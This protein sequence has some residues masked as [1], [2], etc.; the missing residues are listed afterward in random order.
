MRFESV[1]AHAF[2]PFANKRLEFSPG[3][4]VIYGP[5]ESG[6][7]TW[8][9]VLYAGL[10]GLRRARGQ[11]R[12]D[13]RD[14]ADRHKPWD[15]QSWEVSAR[16][17]LDDGRHIE[18]RHDLNG[19]ADCAATDLTLGRDVTGEIINEGSPDGARWLGLDRRSFLA[20]AC[21][22]QAD[23][24]GIRKGPELL[25]EHLQRAA[26][27]TRTD[28]TATEAITRLQKFHDTQVGSDRARS[29]KPFRI[30]QER[31][32]DAETRLGRAKNEHQGFLDL[33]AQAEGL[34]C[35]AETRREALR[36]L[37]ALAA[38]RDAEA[39][40]RRAS[41]ARELAQR[42]QGG[43][44][45]PLAEDDALARQIAAAI[46]SWE[47]RSRVAELK[48]LSAVELQQRIDALPPMPDGD[49]E[50]HQDIA[51]A[52]KAYED[53]VRVFELHESQQLPTS[54]PPERR[55]T[56]E[57]ELRD[58]A[59]DLEAAEPSIDPVLQE[60]FQQARD[61][62][63]RLK[64]WSWTALLAAAGLAGAGT[65]VWLVVS[66]TV[67]TGLLV[68]VAAGALVA[69]GLA[70]AGSA[71]ARAL[72]ELR[73]A[74]SAV[75]GIRHTIAE[76]VRLREAA[77]DRAR[78]LRLSA[79]PAVLRAL[80]DEVSAAAQQRREFERWAE[81]STPLAE[82][83][84]TT[85]ADLARA[86]R[87]RG[88][89]VGDDVTRALE[90][91]RSECAGRA[92]TAVEAAKRGQLEDQLA[93]R[94]A[95]EEAL[96]RARDA[97]QSL[98]EAAAGA[99]IAGEDPEELCHGLKAWQIRALKAHQKALADWAELQALLA[100]RTLEAIEGEAKRKRNAV[101]SRTAG[102]DPGQV[103]AQSL[104]PDLDD[105]LARLRSE[106][107]QTD[108]DAERVQGQLRER[109]RTLPSVSEAEEE[110][111]RAREELDRVRRLKDTIE[112]TLQFLERAQDQVHR[113][114]APIL[115]QTV[116]RWL[117]E[118][119]AQ[120]YSDA[121]VDPETLEVRVRDGEGRWR[122]AALLS[123][124]TTEQVYLLL[125]MAMAEHLGNPGETCP[126]V[127]DDVTVQS[128]RDRTESI[129]R[130][131]HV[132]SRGRQ[133]IIF[134]Q[135]DE[136]LAWAQANLD[137]TRDNLVQLDVAGASR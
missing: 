97:E 53:A 93:A 106:V 99:G 59:R 2:G 26:A 104:A 122:N 132:I 69:W 43:Q 45:Q 28:A 36:L 92:R 22:R 6:K 136:I 116:K 96:R 21:V 115:A 131:L 126:L 15:A 64:T 31:L 76:V 23:I 5:N 30:A 14:F 65:G 67:L 18:L 109:T 107:E 77:R 41:R 34:R 16:V 119:T 127:V 37:E 38:L 82:R 63:D 44:P 89:Q 105:R 84:T 3:M 48:G 11:S 73:I 10:C 25:Q 1:T 87:G 74:E 24:L 4:T 135:E 101:E 58:L 118:V 56:S 61:R 33:A 90:A 52:Q 85:G 134:S 133:V 137:R 49:L 86:L 40:E 70:G 20:T 9:A 120:R 80:A 51:A 46:A 113:D 88:I 57:Q 13:E 50:P 29:T 71:R 47:G 42:Y 35:R 68:L 75:G 79:N 91:Y 103:S 108:R 19:R 17:R 129:M 27:T 54:A 125:R 66:G 112:L 102:L 110:V 55:G 78:A 114:I 123:H 95:A 111:E 121:T 94:L 8:H 130:C 72:E 128:D 39:S 117:P 32:Q 7:S 62:A 60:R 100:G 98:R 124:G 81:R 12:A 83:V